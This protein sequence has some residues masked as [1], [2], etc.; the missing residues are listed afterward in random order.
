MKSK[1][2]KRKT[3]S[4]P[5]LQGRGEKKKPLPLETKDQKYINPLKRISKFE[6]TRYKNWIKEKFFPAKSVLINMELLNGFH[7]FFLVKEKENGFKFSGK[8]YIFDNELKY[9][10]FD[11]KLWCYD[12]HQNFCMPIKRKIPVTDVIKTIEESSITEVEY[13]T[14]PSTLERFITSKIAEGIMKGQQID[15]FF[16]RISMLVIIILIISVIHLCLFLFKT[17]MLQSIK[18]PGINT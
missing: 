3:V 14:N 11:S 13:A 12:Y 2:K 9:Y 16:K 10:C 6:I 18:I 4:N 17:G 15:E 7:R 5:T 8:F 1:N